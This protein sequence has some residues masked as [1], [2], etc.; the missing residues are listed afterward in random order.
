MK[1]ADLLIAGAGPAGLAAAI[2]AADCGLRVTVVE[3]RR[4]PLD[5]PCGEGIMPAGVALL[6]R[7]GIHV[8]ALH[9]R[10]FTGIRFVDGKIVAEG[11]FP[12]GPGLGVR[13]TAL[14]QAMLERASRAGVEVRFGCA[15][16]SFAQ[17]RRSVVAMTSDGEIEAAWLIGADGLHSRVR[18]LAGLGGSPRSE[19]RRFGMRRH[20]S[21]APWTTCV[22]VHWSDG[23]E[24]YVTPVGPA[25]VGVALL[26]NGEHCR[27][28]ELLGRFPVLAQCLAGAPPCTEIAGAG[29]L[30]QRVRRRYRGR[31]ALIGDAAGYLDPLTGEGITLGLRTARALLETIRAGRPPWHYEWAY[32]RQSFD[33][34]CLTRSL[35][36]IAARPALRRRLVIA[37]ARQSELFG[38]LLGVGAGEVPVRS[39]GVGAMLRLISATVTA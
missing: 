29:P 20:F 33:Y 36:E 38:A 35:L 30:R 37:L 32:R 39:L 8:P 14:A 7:L 6:H 9:S 25:E 23:A 21:V 2:E 10:P 17:R 18:A 16:V 31:V 15:L 12:N 11:R 28:D 24:A 26:W 3:K 1:D 22:E 34:Y 13:R 4:P 19:G 27:Y 5:K